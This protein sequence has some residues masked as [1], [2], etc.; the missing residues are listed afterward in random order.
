M[1]IESTI[2]YQVSGPVA[3][4][5]MNR[6]SA[7]NA[8]NAELREALVSALNQ[9]ERDENVRVVVLGSTGRGFSAGADVTEMTNADYDPEE[10]LRKGYRP[11]LDKIATLSKPVMGVAPGVAAGVGA[12][13][14]MSCDLIVMATEA[15]IFMAFS[16]IGLIPDGGSTWYLYRH[17]GYQRAFQLIIEGGSIGADECLTLGIANKVVPKEQLDEVAES[18][19]RDLA[20]RSPLATGAAKKLLRAAANG[21][22]DEIFE[23]EATAQGLCFRSDESKAAIAALVQKARGKKG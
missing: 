21:T 23:R 8:F 14:L 12:A 10:E 3:C 2:D 5:R 16:H 1:S 6:S 4:I 18:W 19:A 17:L 7:L 15:R 9:A 13:V 20:E 11:L 22:Y